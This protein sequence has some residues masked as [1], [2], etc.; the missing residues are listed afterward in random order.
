MTTGWWFLIFIAVILIWIFAF[1]PLRLKEKVSGTGGLFFFLKK[2]RSWFGSLAGRMSSDWLWKLFPLATIA[3]V[4]AVLVFLFP[5]QAAIL[6]RSPNFW[7]IAI[8]LGLASV[9][10]MAAKGEGWGLVLIIP[11]ILVVVVSLNRAGDSKDQERIAESSNVSTRPTVHRYTMTLSGKGDSESRFL[12]KG[13]EMYIAFLEGDEVLIERPDPWDPVL[14]A[15]TTKTEFHQ[16][17]G[18]YRFSATKEGR[19]VLR[20]TTRYRK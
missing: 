12:E 8:I 20:I 14:L 6:Y 3:I 18:S 19:T 16:K 17:V 15:K 9:A 10:F 7:I 1:F 2:I 4:T 11:A 5:E 13:A